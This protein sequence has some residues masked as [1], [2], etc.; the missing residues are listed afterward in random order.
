M[1]LKLLTTI[2]TLAF[3]DAINVCAIAVLTLVLM[4]I[5][6]QNPGNKKKTLLSGLSFILA[7]YIMYFLY[8]GIIFTFFTGIAQG[9][10]GASEII[11]NIFI[12]LIL[13]IGAL[14]I[15]D[16]FHYKAGSFGTEMPIF[17]RPKMKKWVKKITSPKGAF[18]IGLFVTLFLLTCTMMPLFGAINKLTNL[19]YS[20]IRIAPW[21]LYY[22]FIFVIPMLIVTFL[23]SWGFT[24]VDEVSGWKEKNIRTLHLIAGILM[25]LVGLSLLMGWL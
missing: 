1:N 15:K 5:L 18:V 11:Y 23:V 19:G 2:T 8:G 13:I 20:F 21:L 7:V 22:N 3:V 25:F 16:F 14:Q 12:V 17:M 6:I 10:K 24:K 4:N 9:I